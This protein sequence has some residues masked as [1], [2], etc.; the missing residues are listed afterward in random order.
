MID[1]RILIPLAP[2]LLIALFLV[3]SLRRADRDK[4]EFTRFGRQSNDRIDDLA[5][6]LKENNALLRRI[7]ERLERIERRSP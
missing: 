5:K 4:Q 3:L 6:T 1:W 2:F 7:E